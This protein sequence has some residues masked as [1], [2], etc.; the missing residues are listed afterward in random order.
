MI[1]LML[2]IQIEVQKY[3]SG[4]ETFP[5]TIFYKYSPAYVDVKNTPSE[6]NGQKY[7]SWRKV[8]KVTCVIPSTGAPF[9]V[10]RG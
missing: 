10:G 9:R 1:T 5:N 8:E 6:I 7:P 3:P 4:K 2:K